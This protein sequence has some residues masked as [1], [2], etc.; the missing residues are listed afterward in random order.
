[1]SSINS[2]PILK[3]SDISDELKDDIFA[4]SLEATN[5]FELERDIA[6]SIKKQLD[7]KYDTTWHVIV[8]KNFGSYVTHEKG[9]FVYFYIGPL[10]YLVF[11]T[12]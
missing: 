3:A 6:G 9:H 10:A 2:K 12:A 8:G 11:K 4:I 1:M 5:K 7:L